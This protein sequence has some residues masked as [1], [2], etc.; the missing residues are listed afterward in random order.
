MW[1]CFF[2]CLARYSSK[3]RKFCEP[4]KN[5]GG[6]TI[7][8]LWK[9][10]NPGSQRC[11]SFFMTWRSNL[12]C[13]N[14]STG[15]CTYRPMRVAVLSKVPFCSRSFAGIA[16]SNPAGA[17]DISVV[18]IVCVVRSLRRAI[19]Y[20]RVVLPNV[21]CQSVNEASTM[22]PRPTKAVQPSKSLTKK[23][24]SVHLLK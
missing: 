3:E 11:L 22:R 1:I 21:V 23:C 16:G 7:I 5:F 19:Y 10:G 15:N 9:A 4:Y 20:S 6:R 18:S 8:F 14:I 12:H 2:P 24:C 17:M 13:C